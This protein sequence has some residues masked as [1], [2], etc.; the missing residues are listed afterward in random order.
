MDKQPLNEAIKFLSDYTGLNIV[1]DAKGLADE[2]L[3]LSSPVSLTVN[4]IQIRSALNLLLKPLGLTYKIENEVI[5]ITSP[6]AN[7]M[8]TIVKTY[9]VGDLLMPPAKSTGDI[10]QKGWSNVDGTSSENSAPVLGQG[11]AIGRPRGR[12]ASRAS[13]GRG[14]RSPTATAGWWT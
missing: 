13:R 10:M 11:F 9:Y 14:R 4:N 1:S 6:Q 5:V 8:D 7:P 3:S 2:G 12:A